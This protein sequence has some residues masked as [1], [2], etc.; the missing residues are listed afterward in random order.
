M[1]N[2]AVGFE[3]VVSDFRVGSYNKRASNKHTSCQCSDLRL[4]F[5]SDKLTEE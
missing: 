3:N 1:L 5:V 4:S 2:P